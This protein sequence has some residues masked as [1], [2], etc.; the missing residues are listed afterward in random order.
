MNSGILYKEHGQGR[1]LAPPHLPPALS[2][3]YFTDFLLSTITCP[4]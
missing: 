1:G 3:H 4:D 2:T